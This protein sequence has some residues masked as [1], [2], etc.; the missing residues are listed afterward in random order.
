[1]HETYANMEVKMHET[2]ANMEMKMH[3][4]YANVRFFSKKRETSK[5]RMADP[6]PEAHVIGS[7][8]FKGLAAIIRDTSWQKIYGPNFQQMTPFHLSEYRLAMWG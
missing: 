7:S 4:T 1:M 5:L 8:F 6:S 3:E 2:Y